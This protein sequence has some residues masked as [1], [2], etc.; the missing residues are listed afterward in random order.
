MLQNYLQKPVVQEAVK[1]VE[2]EGSIQQD[3]RSMEAELEK[4][5]QNHYEKQT[6]KILCLNI[7]LLL[8]NSKC[9]LLVLFKNDCITAYAMQCYNKSSIYILI[10]LL[11]QQI[12]I[13]FRFNFLALQ[14]YL[15]SYLYPSIP[16]A[17]TSI[18]NH[19]KN[20]LKYYSQ[21]PL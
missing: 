9:H 3:I 16:R 15:F 7:L 21:K 19:I 12:I 18:Y 10:L 6:I 20:T 8:L 2:Q 17:V 14:H 13:G 5:L 11:V 1:P 4:L